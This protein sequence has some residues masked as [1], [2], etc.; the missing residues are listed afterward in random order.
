VENNFSEPAKNVRNFGHFL[1]TPGDRVKNMSRF[2][3]GAA[4]SAPSITG[5]LTETF[6]VAFGKATTDQKL[7]LIECRIFDEAK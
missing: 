1:R 7:A 5:I 3:F 2:R 4:K 6:G